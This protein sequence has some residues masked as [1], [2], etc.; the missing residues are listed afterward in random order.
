MGGWWR[1]S[2]IILQYVT[3]RSDQV[4]KLQLYAKKSSAARWFPVFAYAVIV[5]L[6]WF[7][8]GLFYVR[9]GDRNFAYL[10]SGLL[11][12]FLTV[13]LPSLYRRYQDHFFA[14][15]LTDDK[16][17]GLVGP[18]ELVVGPEQIEQKGPVTT[19]RADWRDV[20]SVERHQ[21]RS[22]IFAAPLIAIVVPDR[23]FASEAARD[24]FVR[25]VQ[26]RFSASRG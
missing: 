10:A 6:S 14:S 18:V 4:A 20:V 16:L 1:M 21:N 3:S 26:E 22:F 25:T 19:I 23:G 17:R 9:Q 12:L 11:A 8:A 13:A 2:E 24:E 5:A 15:V 7:S